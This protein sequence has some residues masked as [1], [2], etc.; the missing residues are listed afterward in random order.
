MEY[1]GVGWEEVRWG[2][3]ACVGGGVASVRRDGVERGKMG[4][5]KV[6]RVTVGRERESGDW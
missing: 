4:R 3:L 6:E 2:G 1:E 5:G